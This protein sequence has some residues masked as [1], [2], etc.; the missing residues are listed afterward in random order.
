MSERELERSR[1]TKRGRHK[2]DADSSSSESDK[3]VG[4]AEEVE[5]AL[6]DVDA[7]EIDGDATQGAFHFFKKLLTHN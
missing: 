1:S 4:E 3:D 5:E 7:A 6:S 2:K